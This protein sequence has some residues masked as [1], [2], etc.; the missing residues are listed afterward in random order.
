[1]PEFAV[2]YR[3]DLDARLMRSAE[4]AALCRHNAHRR[5]PGP[6]RIGQIAV[7]HRSLGFADGCNS[8]HR[9]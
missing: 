1:M 5:G 8:Q 4:I 7:D 6:H 9:T 2:M 3:P